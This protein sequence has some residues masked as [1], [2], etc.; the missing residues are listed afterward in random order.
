MK[1]KEMRFQRDCIIRLLSVCVWVLSQHYW[2]YFVFCQKVPMFLFLLNH[3]TFFTFV[4]LV[5]Y[6]SRLYRS[7]RPAEREQTV[8]ETSLLTAKKHV[9]TFVLL[10]WMWSPRLSLYRD[11]SEPNLP[12]IYVTWICLYCI[13]DVI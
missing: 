9:I 8:H 7:C 5:S 12:K 13:F 4:A 6:F 10:H 2:T 3:T 1:C 11:I